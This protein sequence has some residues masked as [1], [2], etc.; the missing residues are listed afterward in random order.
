MDVQ[1]IYQRVGRH[2]AEMPDL[3]EAPI[4]P[5]IRTW[6]GR[7]VALVEIAGNRLDTA[8]ISIS[9]QNLNSAIRRSNA[10]TI[11]AVLSRVHARLEL[12][13]PVSSQGAF[14]P[15]GNTLDALAAISTI[16]NDA[17][18][19]VLI[20]DPYAD[21]VIVTDFLVSVPEG[22]GVRLLSDK[23]N[24]KPTL[25]P[26]VDRYAEQFGSAR[27]LEVRVGPKKSL[28]DRL[29]FVDNK[30]VYTMGNPSTNLPSVRTPRSC[31]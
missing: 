3:F 25:K 22:V 2:M 16:L 27:S 17:R 11:I 12:Q 20:V 21:A 15:A 18:R 13:L 23:A 8:E 10:E 6:L 30:K 29:I 26:A 9:A 7:A 19:D 5:E 14:L 1:S 4:T 31:E 28:H 24:L